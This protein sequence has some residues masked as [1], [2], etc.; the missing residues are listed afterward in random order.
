MLRTLVLMYIYY[1][2]TSMILYENDLYQCRLL[3]NIR[4]ILITHNLYIYLLSNVEK[5]YI[6]ESTIYR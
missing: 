4:R 5:F 1:I 3:S 6:A 2:Y